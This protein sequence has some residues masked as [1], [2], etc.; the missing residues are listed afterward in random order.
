MI[1]IFLFCN[2][3]FLLFVPINDNDNSLSIVQFSTKINNYLE[4]ASKLDKQINKNATKITNSLNRIQLMNLGIAAA[5]AIC[6]KIITC[7][8][9]K[10]AA[11]G[12]SITRKMQLNLLKFRI[13]SLKFKLYK[14][15]YKTHEFSKNPATITCKAI[16]FDYPIVWPEELIL[17]AKTINFSSDKLKSPPGG[18]KI[19]KNVF[20]K[21]S[22]EFYDE[23]VRAVNV[24]N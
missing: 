15:N 12:I 7:P 20:N 5:C 13:Q 10:K 18:F 17:Q 16:G 2:I 11:K 1:S 14:I 8:I 23:R 6:L 3:L 22:W 24:F 19:N 9:A 4:K 21:Y